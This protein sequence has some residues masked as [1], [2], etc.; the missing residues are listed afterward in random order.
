[1]N[2]LKYD[3]KSKDKV[4][5]IHYRTMWFSERLN[6]FFSFIFLLYNEI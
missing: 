6:V 5:T 3:E 2:I 1:M 4:C